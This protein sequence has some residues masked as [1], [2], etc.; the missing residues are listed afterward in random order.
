MYHHLL[1]NGRTFHNAAVRSQIAFQHRKAACLAVRIVDGADHLGIQV[2]TVFNV[3]AYC[4]SCHRHAVCVKESFFVQ[5][6]HHRVDA[7]GF[8]E[9]LDIGGAC[10]SKMTEIRSF[11]TDLICKTDIEIHSDLVSDRRKVKHT[12][13]GAA[14]GHIHGQSVQNRLLRHDVSRTDIL[15]VHFHYLHT[16]MFRKTDTLG[17]YRGDG[18]IAS[19]AHSQSLGEAVHGIGGIH[20]GTGSA[21]GA[22]F[23][24]KLCKL[25]FRDLAGRVGAHRLKHTGKTCLMAVDMSCHHGA[26]ADE[27]GGNIDPGRSHQK[28]RDILVTVGDHDESV[29]LMGDGHSLCGIRDQISGNKRIFHSDMSHGDTVADGDCRKYHRSSARHGYALFYSV[30]D[31]I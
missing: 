30:Y 7:A 20:T 6:V 22:G 29:K 10:R 1:H 4:L 26:A 11:L 25:L 13:G 23:V 16:R 19:Q 14:K 3:L 12:V 24:F 15:P 27:H 21:G 28:A 9:I 2:Y 17:I 31:F 18:P 8:I 5:L